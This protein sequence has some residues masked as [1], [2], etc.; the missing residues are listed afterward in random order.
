MK[1]EFAGIRACSL[2]FLVSGSARR[3]NAK[4]GGELLDG[5]SHGTPPECLGVAQRCQLSP[6]GMPRRSGSAGR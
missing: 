2:V 5:G 1:N 6:E 4:P 3:N